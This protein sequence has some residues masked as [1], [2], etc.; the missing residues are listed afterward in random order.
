MLAPKLFH[1]EMSTTE[2]LERVNK[3]F[4]EIDQLMEEL[5]KL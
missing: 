3:E 5:D 1:S 2:L 4:L